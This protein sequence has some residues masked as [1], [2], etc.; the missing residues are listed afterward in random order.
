MA[1]SG[2]R[3]EPDPVEALAREFLGRRRSG[4]SPTVDEYTARHP[5][6]ADAIRTSFAALAPAGDPKPSADEIDTTLGP[7]PAATTDGEAPV[8][9]GDFRLLREIGRGGMGVVYEVEQESLGRRVALKLLIPSRSLTPQQIGR[10]LR[11]ARAAARLHH[12]NIV[13]VHGV[14][15]LGALHYYVMQLISGLGL[16]Q[17]LDEVRRLRGIQPSP[18]AAAE[19]R[20]VDQEAVGVTVTRLGR[21][22]SSGAFAVA[23]PGADDAEGTGG[24]A[25]S[26]LVSQ[27]VQQG[28]SP[29]IDPDR[30]YARSVARIGL[31]VASALEYAHAQGVLHRD[32]K[33]AN[34][35][36]DAQGNVW[37][38]DFGLAKATGHADLT[39][40]ND[41]L[42]TLRYMAPER[43]RGLCD[44]RS[45]VFALGLTLYE[46]LALRPAYT[47]DH[48]R[49]SGEV[50]REEPPRLRDTCPW[51]PPDLEAIV[52]KAMDREPERRYGTAGAMAEDLQRFLDD[53]PV[54]ARPVGVVER[55][56]RRARRN[57]AVAGLAAAVFGLLLTIASVSSVMAWRLAP[58]PSPCERW[59]P[60]APRPSAPPVARPRRA[61]RPR[62]QATGSGTP[63]TGSGAGSTRPTC[64]WPPWRGTPGTSPGSRRCSTA[65][66]PAS[67]GPTCDGSSG[68]TGRDAPTASSG[69]CRARRGCARASPSAPTAPGSP[70]GR[71]GWCWSGTSPGVS[72]S[73]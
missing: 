23:A 41:V 31:Q 67:R 20:T 13:P 37:V 65:S 8:R 11:E 73:S 61:A 21:S 48:T 5:E 14:G 19:A 10:F 68:T 51:L 18:S 70:P 6:L 50:T 22:L 34:L 71:S 45:D 36:L 35:L 9:L 24:Q 64:N 54:G 43:F 30:R 49:L 62:P 25:R 56:R 59:W 7:G 72:R 33:P 46:L 12:T 39:G 4:E 42:G 3:D 28:L 26:G 17:V 58:R 44:A 60:P 16:D 15:E 55:I 52:H 40:T 47:A 57:P 32:I 27:P 2:S 66:C 29:G 69:R 1:M 38:A 63:A 53:R